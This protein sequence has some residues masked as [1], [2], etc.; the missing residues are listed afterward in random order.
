MVLAKPEIF[1]HADVDDLL[2]RPEQHVAGRIAK[3]ERRGHGKRSGIEPAL[4]VLIGRIKI[5]IHHIG[6]PAQPAG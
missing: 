5:G 2:P 3:R 1:Q 6:A 4:N